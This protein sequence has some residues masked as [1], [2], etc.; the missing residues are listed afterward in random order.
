M[1]TTPPQFIDTQEKIDVAK[2]AVDAAKAQR[3]SAVQ[4]VRDA[5]NRA[6]QAESRLATETQSLASAQAELGAALMADKPAARLQEKVNAAGL[7]VD[8]L[9]SLHAQLSSQADAL[10]AGLSRTFGPIAEAEAN[11]DSAEFDHL[12]ATYAKMIAPA[13]PIAAEIRQ[14]SHRKGMSMDLSG[15]LLD[16]RRPQIGPFTVDANG[17]LFFQLR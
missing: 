17:H 10:D 16:G 12:I 4:A 3:E 9:R 14:R 6:M 15:F 5:R 2:A 1:Q 11:L 8:S 7:N 13:I